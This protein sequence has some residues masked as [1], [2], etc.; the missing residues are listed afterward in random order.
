[1]NYRDLDLGIN[2]KGIYTSYKQASERGLKYFNNNFNRL[3]CIKTKIDPHN[4]FRHEQSIPHL[5]RE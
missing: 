1:M 3:V 4:F 5:L 2:N